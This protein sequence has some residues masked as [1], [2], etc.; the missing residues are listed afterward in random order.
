M[1]IFL[2]I[3]ATA[4]THIKMQLN[5]EVEIEY[6]IIVVQTSRGCCMCDVLNRIR[7]EK[8]IVIVN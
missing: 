5:F 3:A 8:L 4:T 7:I 2:A 6:V 1:C